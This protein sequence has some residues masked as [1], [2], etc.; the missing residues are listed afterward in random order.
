MSSHL[1]ECQD[2]KITADK[3][4]GLYLF[5]GRTTS[6][7]QRKAL[8][9]TITKQQFDSGIIKHST[10]EDPYRKHRPEKT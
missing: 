8:L 10:L 2:V 6:A 4:F 1:S 3:T 7:A 9:N 5:I